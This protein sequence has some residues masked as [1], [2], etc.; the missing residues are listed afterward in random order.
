MRIAL[1][2]DQEEALSAIRGLL[3]DFSADHPAHDIH[4]FSFSSGRALLGA[5]KNT[6]GFDLYLL[7]ILMPDISGIDLA[8]QLSSVVVKPYVI[9]LTT[10]V[11]YTLHAFSVQARNY[12]LKPV[13]RE[14]LFTALHT[15]LSDLDRRFDRPFTISGGPRHRVVVPLSSIVYVE[16][17]R[18]IANFHLKDGSMEQYT[19]R[20]PFAKAMQ[21]LLDSGLF[22]QPHQSFVVNLQEIL[23]LSGQT[24]YLTAGLKIP[25]ARSRLPTV[26]AAYLDFLSYQGGKF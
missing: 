10:S 12:L 23:R 2:D 25:V 24:I 17:R 15:A 19:M 3:A 6:G 16:S 7:D 1:C 5:V 14:A 11:E 9:F 18:H 13:T 21:E 26:Q 4:T 20:E 8:E 22:I